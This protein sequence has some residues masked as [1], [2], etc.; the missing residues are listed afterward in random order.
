MNIP[1]IVHHGSVAIFENGTRLKWYQSLD[2]A[3]LCNREKGERVCDGNVY[4]N[5][6][7]I[8]GYEMGYV[9]YP[10]LFSVLLMLFKDTERPQRH[11]H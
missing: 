7:F 10:C 2:L 9:R 3:R 4:N 1:P 6:G 5:T 8:L 11:W